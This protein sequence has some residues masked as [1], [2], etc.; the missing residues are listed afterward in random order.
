[1]EANKDISEFINVERLLVLNYKKLGLNDDELVILLLTYALLKSGNQFINP[2]DLALLS[3][4]TETKIDV[5]FTSLYAKGLIK[6]EISSEGKVNT[7]MDELIK[8]ITLQLTKAIKPLEK[9]KKEEDNTSLYQLL[10]TFFGRPLSPLEIDII[11]G[12]IEKKYSLEMIK[13]CIEMSNNQANRSIRYLDTILFEENKKKEM[14]A[15]E[16]QDRLQETI[17]LSKIDWLNK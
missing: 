7:N 11:D 5:I 6:T 17:E 8:L 3:N 4:F 10:E 2:S 9:V 16:Y 13:N 1:M 14:S 15:T 12:W